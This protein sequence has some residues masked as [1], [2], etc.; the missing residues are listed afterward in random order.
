M[1]GTGAGT[2]SQAF[3]SETY[4]TFAR[5]ALS[6]NTG[7]VSADVVDY[8]ATDKH[9]TTLGRGNAFG[10]TYPISM[11]VTRWANT[12]AITSVTVKMIVGNFAAGCTLYLYGVLG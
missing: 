4:S 10:E 8:S 11:Y 1:G 12:A 6:G 9:K 7:T 3:S 2:W 5:F